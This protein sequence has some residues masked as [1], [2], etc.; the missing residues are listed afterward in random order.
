AASALGKIGQLDGVGE[1]LRARLDD[2]AL[3]VR[4]SAINAL[5]AL[6]DR[7]AIPA[8]IRAGD[9]EDTRYQATPALC[10]LP[11]L[12]AL[13]AYLRGVTDKSQDGRKAA[14]GAVQ[15]IRAQAAPVLERLG[16]RRELSPSVI[17]ELQKVFTAPKPVTSWQLLGPFSIK[18][19]LPF[20]PDR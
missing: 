3:E 6:A 1:P 5:G 8:L 12:R 19:K 15:K 14:A 18:D 17:S 10:A 11:T 9:S 4:E 7:E 16:E 13:Q 2:P 20:E